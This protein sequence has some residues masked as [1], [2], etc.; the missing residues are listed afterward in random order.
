M[1]KLNKR[2]NKTGLTPAPD[3]H[4]WKRSYLNKFAL[5]RAI[6]NGFKMVDSSE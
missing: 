3:N 4:P 1:Q 6:K 2:G 5:D